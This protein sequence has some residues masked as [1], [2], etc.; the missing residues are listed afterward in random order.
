MPAL[1][2]QERHWP[3]RKGL[4]GQAELPCGA[5]PFAAEG[6]VWLSPD[7]RLLAD[8]PGAPEDV[9]FDGQGRR[10]VLP[11]GLNV[12]DPVPVILVGPGRTLVL[13]NVTV[14]N[15]ESL[16]A[17]LQLAAGKTPGLCSW[18]AGAAPLQQ[19]CQDWARLRLAAEVCASSEQPAAKVQLTWQHLHAARPSCCRRALPESKPPPR[20]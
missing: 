8:A 17:C 2:R 14:V 20:H 1:G 6:D 15:S 12:L 19:E 10:L 3:L 16:S 9:V 4:R 11:G 5:G 13:K 18:V 7:T